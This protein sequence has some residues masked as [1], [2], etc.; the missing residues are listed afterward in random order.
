M[1]TQTPTLR[2]ADQFDHL[3]QEQGQESQKK[4]KIKGSLEEILAGFNKII[5]MQENELDEGHMATYEMALGAAPTRVS[6]E[7]LDKLLRFGKGHEHVA[8]FSEIFGKY[9]SAAISRCEK[10]TVALDVS[11]FARPLEY[12]GYRSSGKNVIVKGD[13]GRN[14]G[15]NFES[16]TLV[17]NGK[18]F[19]DVGYA[20]R[21][22]LIRVN[23]GVQEGE[24]NRGMIGKD[25][26][27]GE[28]EVNGETDSDI[29]YEMRN[30]KITLNGNLI[31][32]VDKKHPYNHTVGTLMEK[33]EIVINGNVEA[34]IA[35]QIKGGI[36]RINGDVL[37]DRIGFH[38]HGGTIYLNGNHRGISDKEDVEGMLTVYD[39]GNPI[40][41]RGWRLDR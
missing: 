1:K 28:I 7:E 37:K 27:G 12:I 30:G 24:F 11:R 15:N 20:M 35:N 41:K 31:G 13:L 4:I 8:N 10:D 16:G 21:G 23:E 19:G 32:V 6:L 14:T 22:G 5:W 3:K 25:M 26:F 29:G 17:I 36:I 39:N 38:A 40:V 33:G 2:A 18:V 34:F 9:L